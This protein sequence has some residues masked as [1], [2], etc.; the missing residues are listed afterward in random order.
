MF[1]ES[2]GIAM[3][4]GGLLA[5]GACL[6]PCA[7]FWALREG[8]HLAK[9]LNISSLEMESNSKIIVS[10]IQNNSLI[11]H[12]LSPVLFDCRELLTAF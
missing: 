3:V 8:L 9:L 7:E 2:S 11:S 1:E 12:E 4:S 6:V 10:L 5:L